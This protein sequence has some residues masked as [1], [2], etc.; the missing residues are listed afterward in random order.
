MNPAEF[1]EVLKINEVGNI[2]FNR[3][4]SAYGIKP[5]ILSDMKRNR[6]PNRKLNRFNRGL[7]DKYHMTEQMFRDMMDKQRGCC[8][9]CK[10][11]LDSYGK[12]YAH[13]DHNHRTGDVRG[14]LCHHCNTALGGFRDNT[15]YLSSAIKY[16]N[17]YEEV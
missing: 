17:R 1:D 4:A 2:P 11:S 6:T 7:R 14:L 16:L 12:G 10:E 9:I 5:T 13:V 15:N 8:E 3:I